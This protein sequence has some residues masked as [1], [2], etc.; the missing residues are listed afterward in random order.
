MGVKERLYI[1]KPYTR[2]TRLR[3]TREFVAVQA[4]LKILREILCKAEEKCDGL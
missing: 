2:K 4:Y 1:G 3:E